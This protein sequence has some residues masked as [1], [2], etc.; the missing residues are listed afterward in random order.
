MYQFLNIILILIVYIITIIYVNNAYYKYARIIKASFIIIL[1]I[2]FI[3]LITNFS[4]N[5]IHYF[6]DYF[7][8][9]LLI[10][11][12][13]VLLFHLVIFGKI[14]DIQIPKTEFKKDAKFYKINIV[15][16]IVFQGLLTIIMLIDIRLILNI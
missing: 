8:T 13:D 14:K 15:Y 1:V 5:N 6:L 11:I 4:L 3:E 12:V 7:S 16:N 10:I 9:N 2:I